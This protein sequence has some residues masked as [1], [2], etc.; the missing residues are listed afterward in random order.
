MARIID[1]R[2]EDRIVA[3]SAF[4]REPVGDGTTAAR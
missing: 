2:D 1:R 4:E 3:G